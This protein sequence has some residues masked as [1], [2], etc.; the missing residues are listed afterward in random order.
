MNAVLVGLTC[1]DAEAFAVSAIGGG[2]AVA[3]GARRAAH[4]AAV[5]GVGAAHRRAERLRIR[6]RRTGGT[7]FSV[8]GAAGRFA[9]CVAEDKHSRPLLCATCAWC[10]RCMCT[11]PVCNQHGVTMPALQPDAATSRAAC[12]RSFAWLLSTALD[13]LSAMYCCSAHDRART[14]SLLR[15][16]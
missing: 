8:V 10:T 14:Q 2:V 11:Q 16:W 1:F 4:A 12:V 9:T 5:R 7:A 6:A 13:P 3:C 15:P